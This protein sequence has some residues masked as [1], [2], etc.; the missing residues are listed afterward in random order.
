MQMPLRL[1]AALSG[2]EPFYGLQAVDSD[3][4]A[5]PA[6]RSLK[7]YENAEGKSRLLVKISAYNI[8]GCR[9]IQ[10]PELYYGA[11]S[12]PLFFYFFAMTF[13]CNN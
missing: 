9:R 10:S 13:N 3:L 8:N 4:K 7:A 11:I 6:H 1:P 2:E 12:L 5:F